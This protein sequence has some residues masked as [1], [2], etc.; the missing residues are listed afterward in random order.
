MFACTETNSTHGIGNFI[1]VPAATNRRPRNADSDILARSRRPLFRS[2][3]NWEL[4]RCSC[5][6]E[7]TPPKNAAAKTSL[8]RVV[9]PFSV[10]VSPFSVSSPF[11]VLD[12]AKPP[13]R[14]PHQPAVARRG[15]RVHLVR[16]ESG[17]IMALGDAVSEPRIELRQLH[18]LSCPPITAN[19]SNP[20]RCC[21]RRPCSFS[22]LFCLRRQALRHP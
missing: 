6:N 19:R 17:S 2:A 18:P 3:R 15:L 5:S 9:S 4:F 11:S 22:H 8:Q 13:G 10:P 1:A 16:P 14:G 12:A 20:I 7:P 21:D